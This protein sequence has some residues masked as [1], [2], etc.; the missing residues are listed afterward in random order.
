MDSLNRRL[1]LARDDRNETERRLNQ[2]IQFLITHPAAVTFNMSIQT[3]MDLLVIQ[4]LQST[5][6]RANIR[7]KKMIT[8]INHKLSVRRYVLAKYLNG[9]GSFAVLQIELVERIVEFAYPNV[10]EI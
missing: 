9:R 4:R 8:K 5:L 7:L 2:M 6:D 1:A 3:I 10:E